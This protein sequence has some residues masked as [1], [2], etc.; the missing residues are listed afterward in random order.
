MELLE[1]VNTAKDAI[2]QS[3]S[4]CRLLAAYL[5]EATPS[6]GNWHKIKAQDYSTGRA[7]LEASEAEQIGVLFAAYNLPAAKQLFS[8]IFVVQPLIQTLFRRGITFSEPDLLRLCQEVVKHSISDF[9]F[10]TKQWIVRC[11]EQVAFQHDLS[12]TLRHGAAL[13]EDS[14]QED[15]MTANAYNLSAQIQ[16]LLH[17]PAENPLHME[18]AWGAAVLADWKAMPDASQKDAWRDL[19]THTLT[20]DATKPSAKW[21]KDVKALLDPIGFQAAQAQITS[22]LEKYLT[23]PLPA[24]EPTS[25]GYENYVEHQRLMT[26]A[27]HNYQAVKGMA[28]LCRFF[29]DAPPARLLGDVALH[30]L[31]KIPGHGP[32]S[33]KVGTACI[34]TLASMTGREPIAQLSRLKT[35]VTYQAAQGVLDKALNE[36]ASRSGLTRGDLEELAVPDFGLDMSGRRHE[37]FGDYC[38]VVSVT[39]RGDVEL[40]WT[41]ADG[42]ALKSVPL[43]IKREH[44]AALKLLKRSVTE[45]QEALQTQRNRL[46]DSMRSAQTWP[47]RI[48]RERYLAHPLL[49]LLSRRL[50]WRFGNQVGMIWHGQITDE[51]GQPLTDLL[52]DT[53]VQLWHPLASDPDC[54]FAWRIRLEERSITQPFKQAHREVYLLTDAERGTRLYSNRFAAHILKQHQFSA[55]CHQRG[56]KYTL[57]GGWDSHNVPTLHSPIYGLSASF[58]V[59]EAAAENTLSASNVYLYVTTGAVTFFLPSAYDSPLPLDQVPPLVLSEVMRDVDLFVGVASIGNDPAWAD[60]GPE[61]RYRAYWQDYAFGDLGETAKTRADVLA[62][63]LPRLKIASRCRLD[64]KFLIVRGDLRTYKVHLGSGNILMEPND[65]YLCI[66]PGRSEDGGELFLPF[67]GDRMLA[68]ILS[69]AFL[70]AG[71]AQIKDKTIVSQIKR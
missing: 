42:K 27:N 14:L 63:L 18:E 10:T 38:A 44:A 8:K 2:E 31:K 6:K 62:R 26:L 3:E 12:E 4:G 47:L 48:W 50:I 43:N 54:V 59:D 58:A 57:Q 15:Y 37:Q 5:E 28:W 21:L 25:D 32:K 55:L 49:S 30:S 36:A 35:R 11:L 52:D 51:N 23:T 20:S 41:S 64:G 68:I 19:L 22:W 7:I 16:T 66:V 69:K 46:E 29:D 71:D 56:W 40:T 67:E 60:G 34:L 33:A 53:P 17:G 39:E 24:S 13:I 61:G 1:T 70:L 45:L 65:Q 9:D